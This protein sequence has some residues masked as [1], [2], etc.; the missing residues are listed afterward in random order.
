[1][2]TNKGMYLETLIDKTIQFSV[3]DDEFFLIKYNT[4]NTITK[5]NRFIYVSNNFVDYFGYYLK[6]FLVIEAKQNKSDVFYFKRLNENQIFVLNKLSTIGALCFVILYFNNHD[7]FFIVEIKHLLSMI[8]ENKKSIK[9]K[10]V[11]KIGEELN[12][13]LPGILDIKQIIKKIIE[14]NDG[15]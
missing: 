10:E 9:Y 11:V 7:A 3:H 14:K 6:H 8:K 12:L 1:M 2:K 4:K 5:R 13:R 15:R